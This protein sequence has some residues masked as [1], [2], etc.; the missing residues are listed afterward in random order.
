MHTAFISIGS[1]IGNRLDNCKK[2]RKDRADGEEVKLIKTSSF[3]ETEPWGKI[4]QGWFINC[5]IEIETVLDA[6]RLFSVIRKVEE[7][8][9]RKREKKVGT[10]IFDLHVLFFDREIIN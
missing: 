1:N 6:Y 8:F 9:K 5:V 2:A 7:G 10:R 4:E 3:Y